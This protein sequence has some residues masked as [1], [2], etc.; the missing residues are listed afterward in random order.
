MAE[1]KES[2]N[3]KE[4]EHLKVLLSSVEKEQPLKAETVTINDKN[5][6][7]KINTNPSPNPSSAAYGVNTNLEEMAAM[8]RGSKQDALDLEYDKSKISGVKGKEGAINNNY[9]TTHLICL[10]M[11]V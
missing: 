9:T 2:A 6:P 8:F 4:E 10:P 1:M 3:I 11:R 7:T 5:H